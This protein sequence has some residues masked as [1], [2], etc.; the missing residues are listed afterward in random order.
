MLVCGGHVWGQPWLGLHCVRQGE[1]GGELRLGTQVEVSAGGSM[2]MLRPLKWSTWKRRAWLSPRPAR[3][4]APGC[5]FR[6]GIG[7]TDVCL[8]CL[9]AEEERT[10]QLTLITHKTNV[11]LDFFFLQ[12]VPESK[13]GIGFKADFGFKVKCVLMETDSVCFGLSASKRRETKGSMFQ[14]RKK[15]VLSKICVCH[16]LR[17]VSKGC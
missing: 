8:L 6:A 13:H 5:P 14:R 12:N 15:E 11:D 2:G 17:E 10:G 3:F 7:H 9:L 1:V 16:Q 4:R